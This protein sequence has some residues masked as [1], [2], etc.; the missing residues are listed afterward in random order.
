MTVTMLCS[1]CNSPN[2][3]EQ[4]PRGREQSL[5]DRPPQPVATLHPLC[6]CGCA[7]SRH[8]AET[9]SR[10]ICPFASGRLQLASGTCG[11]F[12]GSSVAVALGLCP[13]L[14]CENNAAINPCSRVLPVNSF[15][16]RTYRRSRRVTWRQ[17]ASHSEGPDSVVA[18]AAPPTSSRRHLRVS[19]LRLLVAL[20]YFLKL[21]LL[22]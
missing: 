9:E 6:F 4:K 22:S 13:P 10:N 19:F 20:I 16:M 2:H 17:R 5:P 1:H 8:F 3:A 12:G 11:F 15:R 7:Y 14:T 18:E 21:L